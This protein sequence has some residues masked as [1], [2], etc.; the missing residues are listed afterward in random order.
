VVE[1]ITRLARPEILGLP[2]RRPVRTEEGP[3]GIVA[4][5]DS[6]ENPYPSF[7]GTVD[8]FLG[9]PHSAPRL[10]D[11]IDCLAGHFDAPPEGL[12]ITRGIAE[13][14]DLLIRACCAAR[15]DSVLTCPP[16]FGAHVLSARVQSVVV[17]EAPLRRETGFGLDIDRI[18]DVHR[19][20]PGLK[21]VFL[22]TPNDPT[23]NLVSREDVLNLCSDLLGEA[24]VVVDQSYV[25]YSGET[26]LNREIDAHPNLVV[27][28]ALSK[29]YSLAG[30]QVGVMIAHPE[31]IDIVGRI[32]FPSPLT[33]PTIA[34][35]TA[36]MTSAGIEYARANIGRL[37]NERRRIEDALSML[38]G[39]RVHPSDTNFLLVDVPFPQ[40]LIQSMRRSGIKIR[41]CST[42]PG[43]EG[44]VR[45]SIGTYRQNE[46]MLAVFKEHAA[47]FHDGAR[48]RV[49]PEARC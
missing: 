11:A 46:A 39:I 26:P 43:I 22:C 44:S 34:T 30:E 9:N 18:L 23:G 10:G 40:E 20:D 25:G 41:D 2:V 36:A 48:R 45:I 19:S 32:G 47:V 4:Y 33:R 42:V 16:T 21:L 6:N 27:L 3:D 13:A 15:R 28:R 29:E 12:L 24:L 7:P 8:P 17:H 5:L 35:V 37:L 1:E 31:V 38:S 14:T 49:L